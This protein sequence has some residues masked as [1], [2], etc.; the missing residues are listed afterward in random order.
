MSRPLFQFNLNST[1][2]NNAYRCLIT[3]TLLMIVNRIPSGSTHTQRQRNLGFTLIELLTALLVL[4]ALMLLAI[5]G[6][7]R[8]VNSNRLT[9]QANELV[10]DFSMARSEAGARS[11]PVQACIAATSL[12]CATSGSDWASGRI[13]WVDTNG[14][15][16]LEATEIIKYVPPLDGGV[17]MVASGP[18]NTTSMVFQPYGGVSG[19]STWTF[20]LC[21][22]GDANGRQIIMPIT[23]RPI[24]SRIETC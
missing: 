3:N 19:G 13:I 10:S 21:V 9:A 14:N 8:F 18:S 11:R 2:N 24:A 6:Y 12:A 23:G 4:S 17:S 22:P 15:S 16:S 7:Q 20:K 5:P 1:I